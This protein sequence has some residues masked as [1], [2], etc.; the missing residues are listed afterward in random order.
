[1]SA[2]IFL[3]FFLYKLNVIFTVEW[4]RLKRQKILK[5]VF[6]IKNKTVGRSFI[7]NK[8]KTN[9]CPWAYFA[10]IIIKLYENIL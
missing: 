10:F 9:F 7:L 8:I 2:D 1:M 6:W 3:S 4:Y 5:T